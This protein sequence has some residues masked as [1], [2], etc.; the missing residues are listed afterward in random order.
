[1]GV[2]SDERFAVTYPNGD[3]MKYIST[4][5]LCRVVGGTLCA[6]GEESLELRYFAPNNLPPLPSRHRERIEDG[7][8]G[9][10]TAVF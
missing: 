5:F 3:Q 2:Y 9:G 6:D 7:L 10:K 8:R 4:L 1:M